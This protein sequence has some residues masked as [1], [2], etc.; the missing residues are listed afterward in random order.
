MNSSKV[1]VLGAGGHG[2]ESITPYLY[3]LKSEVV[4]SYIPVDYGGNT[5]TVTR[6][7]ELEESELNNSLHGTS[8]H[9]IFPFGDI[10]KLINN[11]LIEIAGDNLLIDVS[12]TEKTILD[13][14][15][16]DITVT[17]DAITKLTEFFALDKDSKSE[18]FEYFEAY[19]AY[20]SQ[21]KDRLN[22]NE[23]FP[24]CL[25]NIWHTFRY[26]KDG[27]IPGINR[28]YHQKKILPENIKIDFTYPQRQV[29]I[30]STIADE[31]LKG[32]DLIDVTS[33]AVL[34]YT[35]KIANKDTTLAHHPISNDII[36]ELYE[37]DLVMIPNGSIA[38]WLSLIN[39]SHKVQDILRKKGNEGRVILMANLFFT[40]NEFPL[41]TY[42]ELVV[43]NYGIPLTVLTTSPQEWMELF[44]SNPNL[45]VAYTKQEKSPNT[46]NSH[47]LEFLNSHPKLSVIK[48]LQLDKS[49]NV[50]G[51]KY[52]TRSISDTLR[53]IFP[54]IE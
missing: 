33:N 8:D 14:R 34:P 26:Y 20:F 45:K 37:S 10:N 18:F 21:K 16:D 36:D 12:N 2:V 27:G 32:E 49:A 7:F 5:G 28:F 15:S 38:N 23:V 46:L 40:A 19:L 54:S 24:T 39:S 13:L 22:H 17:K 4:I 6:M 41:E 51:L 52:D 48:T 44:D 43:D 47:K 50:V 29:L 35:L 31:F 53:N 9:P 30:G 25:G 1:F 42:I 3:S 11:R